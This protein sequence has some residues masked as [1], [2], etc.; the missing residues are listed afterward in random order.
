MALKQELRAQLAAVSSVLDTQM[1]RQEVLKGTD[2]CSPL[3]PSPDLIK[4]ESEVPACS[5]AAQGMEGGSRAG[6]RT[7]VLREQVLQKPEARASQL[8]RGMHA[9]SS[10]Q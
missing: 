3:L 2:A 1:M 4:L 10:T 8:E 9:S 5:E 7:A 6:M